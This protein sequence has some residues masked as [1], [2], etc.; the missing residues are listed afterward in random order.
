M[1]TQKKNVSNNRTKK[2]FVVQANRE[3]M[4]NVLI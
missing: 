3:E 1:E 2:N 4:R